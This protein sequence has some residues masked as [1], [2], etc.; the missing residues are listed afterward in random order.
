L[1]SFYDNGLEAFVSKNNSNK[2]G[3]YLK[4]DSYNNA[5]ILVTKVS[6]F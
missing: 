6:N 1:P 2:I 5:F 4:Y 3:F